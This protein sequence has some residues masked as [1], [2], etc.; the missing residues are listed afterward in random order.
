MVFAT[1]ITSLITSVAT[2]IVAVASCVVVMY[3]RVVKRTTD[4]THRIVNSQRTA[5]Q[6]FI[7]LQRKTLESHGIDVPDDESLL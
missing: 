7:Q 2:C 6:K 4:D 3:S 1:S 5:M